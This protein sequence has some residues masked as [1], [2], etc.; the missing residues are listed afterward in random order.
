MSSDSHRILQLGS[1]RGHVGP[2][3]QPL[4]GYQLC[5]L[6]APISPNRSFFP[7]LASLHSL[8]T[9]YPPLHAYNLNATSLSSSSVLCLP[10]PNSCLHPVHR[11]A[12]ATLFKAHASYPCLA[13]YWL[14]QFK[15]RESKCKLVSYFAILLVHF[16]V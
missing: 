15:V 1:L 5:P 9:F 16:V 4:S 13:S 12:L 2:Y 8:C 7:V 10:Y 3:T 11:S 6:Q 14:T